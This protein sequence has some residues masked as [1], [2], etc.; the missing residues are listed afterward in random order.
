MSPL[1]PKLQR[2]ARSPA[3]AVLLALAVPPAAATASSTAG[4]VPPADAAAFSAAAAV[5]SAASDTVRGF[6]LPVIEHTLDNGMRFLLLPREGPATV[7]F[8]VHVPVGSVHESMGST[9]IAHFLEHLLFKGSTTVGTRDLEAE[10]RLFARMDAVHDTLVREKGRLPGS[11]AGRIERLEGTIRALED[12]ARTFVQA[13]E[14]AEIL[15]RAGGRGLNATTSYEAT[16]YFVELPANRA[17]LWFALEA[18]RMRHPV[19]RGFYT[20]RE[21]I[22]EERRARIENSPGGRL[23]E[24]VV[25]TAFHVHP[26]GVAPIGHMTD[27]LSLSRRDVE[28][29]Y[30]RHYGPSNTTVAIVGAFD[31]DSARVWAEA[32]F[33]PLEPR[34]IP[35]PVLASEP[36][37]RGERRVE[38]RHDAEP[39]LMIGWK[40]PSSYHPDD[41]ALG[42]LTNL[43]VGG[44]DS[45]LYRRL[46][47]EDRIATSITAGGGPR[48]RHPGLFILHAIPR[49]PHTPEEVEAAIYE[50]LD[51]LRREPP[52]ADELERVGRRLEAARVRRLTSNLGLAFQLTGSESFWGDWRKTF[53]L[54]TRM[55]AV[56]AEDIVRVLERDLREE[57][58]TVGVLRRNGTTSAPARPPSDPARIPP[59]GVT[60]DGPPQDAPPGPPAAASGFVPES[61]TIPREI[62][63][64]PVGRAAVEALTFRPLEFEPPRADEHELLGVPVYHLHDP[65]FPLVDVFLQVRGGSS[66]FPREELGPL[67]GLS[68][69]LR[70]GGTLDLSPDSVER[71]EDLLALQIGTGSGG[72]GSFATLNALRSAF[73]EGL[74]LFGDIL[75]RPGFDP[76]IVEVW[77]GQ[78]L[79][80]VRRRTD[81]P[82]GLAYGEFNRLMFGD[83]PVGWVMSEA[84]LAPERFTSDRL[85]R[86]HSR[87]YCRERLILGVAGDLTWEEAEPRLRHFLEAFPPCEEELPEVPLP[88]LRDAGGIYVLP[89]ETE[90]TTIVMAHPGGIRQEDSPEFFASRVADLILGGGGFNSRLMT[91]V[92]SERG[93]TYGASSIWTTPLRHEGL[94]GAVTATQAERTTETVEVLLEV[95]DDFRAEAPAPGEVQRAIDQIANGYVF[96]FESPAQ[97]VSRRMSHRSQDLPEGWLENYLAEIQKVTPE[98]VLDV[99]RR[100]LDPDRMTVLLVGDPAR[101]DPGLENL[102]RVHLLSTEGTIRPWPASP[103][104]RGR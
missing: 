89:R 81:D 22:A 73:D 2:H 3:L 21:V 16:E 7:S 102:G 79:E 42:V 86:L 19:F 94:V 50:E 57:H 55:Q 29:F 83:H 96:A 88:D 40:V 6:E 65:T 75:T 92:R 47:R 9:G 45:R 24:A 59:P 31:P 23:W 25:A 10:L 63:P 103:S 76:A 28:E 61:D 77:R 72:T 35:A 85:R 43:L 15:A 53:E 8:V 60:R 98:R 20:E 27:I 54:Q 71:R 87:L 56:E 100:F 64:R 90:Q 46:V 17:E 34:E 14:Y 93:L 84:D 74:E 99:A 51:R 26:Y 36:E 18:D 12:S 78:E 41:P 69:F 80:R 91:R 44:R 37:Q 95:L 48:G 68:S 104:E 67:T 49:A 5:P 62:D 1:R 39:Q 97:I 11:D 70:S 30:E 66:H 13:A 32:Y 82:T 38:V 58:R 52:T 4:A 101:F 33:G